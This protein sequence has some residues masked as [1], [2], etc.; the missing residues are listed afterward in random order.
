MLTQSENDYLTHTDAGT[1]M[2]E[3]FRRYW[4]PFLLTTELPEA[5][6]APVRVRL[7]GEDLVA[8]RDTNG[9]VGLIDERCPHRG[10][11]MFFAINQECGLMC[12][13]HGWK[14]DVNGNCVD[15]PSDLP[16]SVFKDKVHIT[17]YPCIE[18]A[19]AI[20]AYMG[21]AEKE[22][23]PPNYIMNVLPEENVMASRTMIYCNYLQSMEGNLDSTHLG[24]LHMYYENMIPAD[25]EYDKPGH[26]SPRFSS[27]ITG[28]EKYARIDIQ[29]TDYGYRLIAVRKTPNGNQ[30]VRINNLALPIMSWIAAS[31]NNGAVFTQLPVDDHN[32]MRVGFSVRPDRPFTAG[33][34]QAASSQAALLQ[35]PDNPKLRLKRMD[36]DYHQDRVAQKT[37]N[38]PGVWPIPEQDYVVTETM[39]P[40]M[41]RTKEHLYHG[42]AAIIRLR[43]M[44]VSASRD[45]EEGI[46][47]P[48]MDGSIAYHK[49]RS[50]DIVIGPDDDPWLVA[51]DAGES[52]T[53]GERLR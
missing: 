29:D 4:Q 33:E 12:I 51:T 19:G 49:I 14:F 43:Q 9:K 32:C 6:G 24:T 40:I 28:V 11:S 23:P 52:A 41:D 53:R 35:D 48:G 39:G 47:P 13:Y 26:P 18:S 38:P 16:G 3:L 15:M 50:E 10:A 30:H 42:D 44:L 45:L 34:R 25:L 8:F 31:R 20:W 27:Y 36:N 1:P 7:L 46:E 5:D 21:P 2:G 22:P 37:T 17:S